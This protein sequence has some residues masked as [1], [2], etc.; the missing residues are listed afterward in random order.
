MSEGINAYQ[1]LENA[2]GKYLVEEK[3]PMR[4]GS[5]IKAPFNLTI[6][7][8]VYRILTTKDDYRWFACTK[9]ADEEATDWKG[10]L[11]VEMVHNY[12]H[13][14]AASQNTFLRARAR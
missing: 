6:R 13:V 9:F 5:N 4:K 2:F 3:D 8:I 12:V 1:K 7:D 14:S 10:Y 11:G